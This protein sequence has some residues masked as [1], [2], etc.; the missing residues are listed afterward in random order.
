[1][2]IDIFEMKDDNIN[3]LYFSPRGIS[4]LTENFKIK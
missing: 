3:P 4:L 1:M 2:G